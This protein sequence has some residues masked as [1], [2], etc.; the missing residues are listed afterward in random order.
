MEEISIPEKDETGDF[1][2]DSVE[3]TSSEVYDRVCVCR[4]NTA[5][6]GLNVDQK[7]YEEDCFRLD[8]SL[9][10]KFIGWMEDTKVE[11]DSY[12]DEAVF[13]KS[14]IKEFDRKLEELL[15]YNKEIVSETI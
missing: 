3:D 11:P 10:E 6:I 13:R 7:R 8:L 4:R 2:P 1:S 12:P 14:S 5:E 15:F 9:N